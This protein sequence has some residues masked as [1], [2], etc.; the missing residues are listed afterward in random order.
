MDDFK[1]PEYLSLQ[2]NPA[3]NWRRWRQRFELYLTAKEADKKPDATKIAMLLS[4]IGPEALERFN[5]FEWQTEGDDAKDKTKYKV[6]LCK[7]QK[8][9]AGMKRVVFARCQFWDYQC[10]EGQ[11]FDEF[12]TQLKT[13]TQVCKFLEVDNMVRDKIMFSSMGKSL[14]EQLLREVNLHLQRAVD[15][16]HS[17]EITHKEM[18]SMKSSDGESSCATAI[19]QNIHGI[20]SK[21][22]RAGQPKPNGRKCKRCGREH[23]IR[24]CPAWGKHYKYAMWRC[25]PFFWAMFCQ[26]YFTTDP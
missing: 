16:C 23:P 21:P 26:K 14:K 8:E 25:Q 7:F 18:Q 19:E 13:L 2:R 24:R 3:E 20:R 1:L 15:L 11:P 17:A 5:H 4:A 9:F 12:L 6:V 10:G 22:P